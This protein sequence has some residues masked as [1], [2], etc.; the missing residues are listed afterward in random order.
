MNFINKSELKNFVGDIKIS[1]EFY[2]ALNAKVEE[3][4]KEAIKRAKK[5]HR[6]TLMPRDI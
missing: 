4:V 5:N 3:L 1:N 2:P 6:T